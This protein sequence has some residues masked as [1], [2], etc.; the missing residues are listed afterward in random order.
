M[1]TPGVGKAIVAEKYKIRGVGGGGGG[2]VDFSVEM[3]Y[4]AGGG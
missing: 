4:A 3:R 1:G 2:G